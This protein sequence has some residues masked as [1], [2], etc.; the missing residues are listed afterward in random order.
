MVRKMVKDELSTIGGLSGGLVFG[1]KDKG[2]R[3][4]FD[5][6][7]IEFGTESNTIQ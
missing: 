5:S 7:P 3:K 2:Y 4:G 1:A 6:M